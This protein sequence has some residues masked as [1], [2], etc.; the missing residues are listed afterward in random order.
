MIDLIVQSTL[1][2]SL[3][4]LANLL[5]RQRSAALRHSVWM[6]A[7]AAIPVLAL[8][9]EWASPYTLATIPVTATAAT[10][11][12]SASPLS[13]TTVWM[14]GAAVLLLRL[15]ASYIW[16]SLQRANVS[17][18]MAFGL[19][20]PEVLL[21]RSAARWPS[22]VRTSVELHER[23]HIARFDTWAQLF[24]QVVCAFLWFQPLAWYAAKRAG[25]ERERACDDAVLNQ[26]VDAS[27]Y[28]AHLIEIARES[29]A[30]PIAGLAMA[31]TSTLEARLGA[32]LGPSIQRGETS[33]MSRIVVLVVAGLAIAIFSAIRAQTPLTDLR[34][35]NVTPPKVLIKINPGYTQE[36]KDAQVQGTVVL[37]VE[38]DVDGKAQNI[39]VLKGLDAGLDINA[40]AA[41][42]NWV[43]QP[44]TKDGEPVRVAARVEINFRLQ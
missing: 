7:F 17:A 33:R 6:F 40:I 4:A 22:A 42:S 39:Q 14:L 30:N 44:A 2:F 28:A 35:P 32:I 5:L 36:A 29:Q 20:R 43:F 16:M 19:F 13:W 3:A 24:A 27:L 9:P 37:S 21:P 38:V 23:A 18:P 34:D 12:V 8:L 41:M 1:V 26:G 25:E 10:R 31:R 15:L 11:T